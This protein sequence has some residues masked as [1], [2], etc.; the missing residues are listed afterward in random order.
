[1]NKFDVST[2]LLECIEKYIK[3]YNHM[4][5]FDRSILKQIIIT[6]VE[7]YN[8][9]KELDRLFDNRM[10]PNVSKK[11]EE[12]YTAIEIKNRIEYRMSALIKEYISM[13]K[14][15]FDIK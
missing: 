2:D 5:I 13:K 7:I 10:N 15:Y 6:D 8:L 11:D 9:V 14:T 3:S 1:M 4:S 12:M